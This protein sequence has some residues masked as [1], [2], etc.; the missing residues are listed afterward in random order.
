MYLDYLREAAAVDRQYRHFLDSHGNLKKMKYL[1]KKDKD[2]YERRES[3]DWD[4]DEN[5]FELDK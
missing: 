2:D 3:W 4:E 1:Y 5:D